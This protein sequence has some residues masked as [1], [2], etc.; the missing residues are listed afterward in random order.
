MCR[1]TVQIPVTNRETLVKARFWSQVHFDVTA[2]YQESFV[3]PKMI[4]I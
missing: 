3:K 2:R 1:D 4:G